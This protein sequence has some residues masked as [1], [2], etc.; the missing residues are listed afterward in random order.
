MRFL[1]YNIQYGLGSDGR[2]DLAR[3]AREIEGADVVALQEVDRF[4]QRSGDVDS[5]AVI[6]AHLSGYHW[7]FA[8]N[9]DMHAGTAENPNKRRQFG[10]MLLSRTPILSCRNFPLPKLG[11]LAQHSIQQ[12][13]LEGVVATPTGAVRVYSVHL[14][15]LCAET[16]LPQIE[17]LLDIDRRAHGEGGAWCGGHPDPAAGWNEGEMPPMPRESILMGD[18][19]F[20]PDSTEYARLVGPWTERF[21]RLA[22]RDGFVDAWVAAG[23]D[24]REGASHPSGGRI[25]HV[26]VKADL[27]PRVR[28]AGIK[29]DAKGS[30]HWPVWAD[31]DL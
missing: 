8:A 4:W 9:L 29:D 6:A 24:E 10:T 14:S 7:V 13:A 18:F 15:H 28:A 21:G 25:D 16:R 1:S 22:H 12:G 2:Y 20:R 17:T 3:I 27:A 19:N 30:D 23:H 5:P 26:F 11:T 31:L